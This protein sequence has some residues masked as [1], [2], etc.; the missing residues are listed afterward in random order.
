MTYSTDEFIEFCKTGDLEKVKKCIKQGIKPNIYN[1]APMR[2]AT[3]SGHLEVVKYLASLDSVDPGANGSY[4]I[5]LAS[6]NGHLD[7]VKYLASLDSVDPG[8]ADNYAIRWASWYGHLEVVKYLISIG[9]YRKGI[10]KRIDKYVMEREILIIL[11]LNRK[12]N[13]KFEKETYKLIIK[14]N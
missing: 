8:T 3:F 13:I 5:K 4:V 6:E 2:C 12:Q 1:N 7:V 14:S 11:C 9:A 10:S